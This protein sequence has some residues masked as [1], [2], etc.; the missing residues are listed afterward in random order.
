MRIAVLAH[1]TRGDV[2][3]LMALAAELAKRGHQVR[4]GA[5]PNLVDTP[6][7]LG[8]DTVPIGWDTQQALASARGQEWVN[9]AD[10]ETFL[11]L[12]YEIAGEHGDRLDGEVIDVCTDCEA[13]VSG[14]T[15]EWRATALA[16][17]RGIP[18]IVHDFYPRR[19]NG[20]IPDPLVTTEPQPSA[21]ATRATYRNLARLSW[22]YLRE[23]MLR[24][25]GRLGL[26][27]LPQRSTPPRRPPLELQAYSPTLVPGL[28]W[29]AYRPFVGDLR[30][31]S[32]DLRRL[33]MSA[34]DPELAEWLDA[35][36]PPALITFG[37]THS[38]DPAATLA[39][40]GRV[41]RSLGLR[42]LVVSGWGLS[43][44]ELSLAPELRVV[45]YVDYDVVLPR[46]AMAVHHGSAT[47]TMAGVR[48]G[49]PAM[50]CSSSFD[51]P[52]WGSQLERLGAGVHVRFANLTEDL[53]RSGMRRLMA[54]SVRRRA[55]LLGE[56]VRAEPHGTLYAAD[57]VDK[58]L[59]E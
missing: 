35:G 53:L 59:V 38:P 54:D 7:R 12:L 4:M 32:S 48:A 39:G 42:G 31:T 41:C 27:P 30:L 11:R 9:A 25:R 55:G 52:F 6:R 15:M 28:T 44:A 47:I 40:I 58:Y 22:R 24:F 21:A 20:V 51:Q 17:A 2:Y 46:C 1:G 36:D 5:S 29:D 56:R 18:H 19:E 14:V 8:L 49:L 13:V 23:P 45:S 37:S 57:E 16:E 33:A 3:P 50:V 43:S 34:V 26:P 10:V